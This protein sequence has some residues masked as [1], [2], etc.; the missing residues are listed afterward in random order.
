[1]PSQRLK[2]REKIVQHEIQSSHVK[3]QGESWCKT[4]SQQGF[5]PLPRARTIPRQSLEECNISMAV[6]FRKV[7]SALE[8]DL[9]DNGMKDEVLRQTPHFIQLRDQF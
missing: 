7:R 5:I 3:S 9:R 8:K 1:M 4:L 2:R 6:S